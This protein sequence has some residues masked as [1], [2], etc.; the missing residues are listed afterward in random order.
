MKIRNIFIIFT[1]SGFWHGANWTFVAWGALNALYFLPLMLL[2]RN[3][4]NTDTV[5][6]GRL[7]PNLTELFQM[8]TTF[9]LTLIAWV[10]FRAESMEHAVAYIAGIFTPSLFSTPEVLAKTVVLGVAVLTAVEWVQRDKQHGLQL[11]GVALPTAVR[12]ALYYLIAASIIW[13]G[14]QQQQFIYFQF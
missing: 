6:E 8:G 14:G 7:L 2:N 11:D 4:A 12:W 3:R 9:F 1:V 10:F 13:L 5:A